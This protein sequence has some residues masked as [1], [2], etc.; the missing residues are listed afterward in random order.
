[1]SYE[2]IKLPSYPHKTVF[3]SV[4]KDVKKPVLD[5]V[6]AK[7]I[8]GDKKYDYCFLNCSYIISR[9]RLLSGIYKSLVNYDTDNYKAKT[10]NTEIIFNMSPINNIMDSLKR[11][12]VDNSK[13][14]DHLICI[15]IIDDDDDV[16]GKLDGKFLNEELM[17]LL[18]CDPEQ[19]IKLTDEF[20]KLAID[21][22][23][24]KK[25][26]KL[27]DTKLTSEDQDELSRLVIG[28]CLLRGV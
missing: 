27:N 8:E 1:M 6:K 22:T 4:F 14:Y 23:K 10:V 18:D 12:G 28:A 17:S 11:F 26:Y 3:I 7:L 9:E 16:N 24:V 15:K 25:A 21:I 5:K 2:S 19:N 20:L 13:E